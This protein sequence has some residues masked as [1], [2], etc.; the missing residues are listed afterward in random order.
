MGEGIRKED[1]IQQ[2]RVALGRGAQELT[3]R[4]TG[5]RGACARMTPSG[6]WLVLRGLCTFQ[7]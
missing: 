7:V 3:R 2:R 4:L 5:Y 6:A 1:G